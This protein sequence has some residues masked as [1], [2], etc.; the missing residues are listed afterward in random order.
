MAAAPYIPPTDTGKRDWGDNFSSLITAAPG[1]YGLDAI[2]A[3]AIQAAF[4]DF[5]AAYALAG[6]SGRVPISP[7]TRTVTTVADLNA[8]KH[9]FIDLAR[10][11]AA[12]IRLNPG[13]TNPAKTDLR[14]NLPN[15]VPSPIPTPTTVPLLNFIGAT[16]GQHTLRYAD[17]LTPDSRAKPQGVIAMQLYVAIGVAVVTNPDLASF[18]AAVTVNPTA[19]SFA[20]GD[21]GKVATY[22]GRWITRGRA[23]GGSSGQTGPFG[24][25]VN[26]IVPSL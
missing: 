15:N 26:A 13:V 17:Q 11:Y 7:G 18:Y 14:L 2:A 22:F 10:S 21:A 9:T 12:Q 5:D 1:T 19:I 23:I 24:A 6:T 25:P 8:K 20:P 16:P 3:A 4:D